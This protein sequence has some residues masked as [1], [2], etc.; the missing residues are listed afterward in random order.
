MPN[1]NL[2]IATVCNDAF[3]EPAIVMLRSFHQHNS[4][5]E[6]KI[7]VIHS[8]NRCKL[9]PES[10]EEI[11]KRVPYP[12]EFHNASERSYKKGGEFL[13]AQNARFQ[14]SYLT[15]E[16]FGLESPNGV[17]FLDADLLI[18]RDISELVSQDTF[19]AISNGQ[20]QENRYFKPFTKT[21]DR[22]LN[23]G[24][25]YVPNPGKEIHS[26]IL[27]I[28]RSRDWR[29]A[30]QDSI[31]EYYSNKAVTIFPTT[32]NAHVKVFDSLEKM[33]AMN[34]HILHYLGKHK[35]WGK[36]YG[37]NCRL[38][39]DTWRESAAIF[40]TIDLL[41]EEI[42]GGEISVLGNGPSFDLL[43]SEDIDRIQV[44]NILRTNYAFTDTKSGIPND[45][46]GWV[47]ALSEEQIYRG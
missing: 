34:P 22:Y 44:T 21:L 11:Q 32:F 28:A 19:S 7:V 40:R 5:F 18:L 4:W 24:V 43:T 38:L 33:Q 42:A 8:Q 16:A 13:K 30:D 15:L 27:K 26:E 29:A 35:P 17:L 39:F 6:G 25:F 9:S 3:C 47:C 1:T 46:F 20:N 12:V 14:I 37:S 2:T 31:N 36:T 10:Q 23:G 41:R 45:I